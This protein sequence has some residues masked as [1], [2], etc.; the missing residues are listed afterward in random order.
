MPNTASQSGFMQTEI[1]MAI[2]AM[3]EQA[4][5]RL[6]QFD[7]AYKNKLGKLS[8]KTFAL[9]LTDI[10]QTFYFYFTETDVML[11]SEADAPDVQ[12]SGKTLDLLKQAGQGSG[13]ITGKFRIQGDIE[14]AQQFQHF[15][16][17]LNLDWEEALAM[18]LGNNMA[19]D[20][21]AHKIGQFTRGLFN[22]GKQAQDTTLKNIAD[23]LQTESEINPDATEIQGFSRAVD[24]LRDDAARLQARISRLK[25]RLSE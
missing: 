19:S 20:V 10:E 15:I 22:W 1:K 3:L 2:H 21:V 23:Y 7:P 11:R 16:Q 6:L 12:L 17:S 5:N 13:T 14:T 4:M 24:A 25:Q 9:E 18:L 8:Y